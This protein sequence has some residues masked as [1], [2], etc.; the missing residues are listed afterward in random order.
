MKKHFASIVFIVLMV[1]GIFSCNGTPQT[2]EL[3]D[4]EEKEGWIS[5]F[6][7][8]SL[9]GWHLYR[10]GNKPSVWEVG[11]NELFCNPTNGKEHGD[12]VSDKEYEN[13]DLRFE[14]KMAAD[15]NSGVFINSVEKDSIPAAWFTGPEYQLL[16]SAHP[17]IALEKKRAGCLYGFSAQKNPVS[18]KPADQWNESRIKQEYGRIEFYLNDTL[19]ATADFTL[20]AWRIAISESGFK[21]FPEF[22]RYTK[23]H[24]VLQDWAKGVSFRNI[25]IKEL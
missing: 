10:E 13:F 1:T 15:G 11:N 8:K 22:G 9:N 24:I 12:L 7:G 21:D 6:D 4:E 17:D 19:T 25:K 14:W 23:G 20:P 18:V 3:S 2:N 5:L 16:G